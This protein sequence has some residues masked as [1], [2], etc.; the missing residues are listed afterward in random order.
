MR[1]RRAVSPNRAPALGKRV[2]LAVVAVALLFA[3]VAPPVGSA[4]AASGPVAGERPTLSVSVERDGSTVRYR[5]TVTAP[6]DADRVRLDGAFGVLTVANRSGF[7]AASGGYRLADGRKTA[8]L[9]VS[10]DLANHQ[11]TPLGR[12]GP[13]GPFQAGERWAFAPSPRFHV[14]WWTDG[15][16]E[17]ARLRGAQQGSGESAVTADQPVAVGERFVFVGP[18]RVAT[19]SVDGR[20]VRLILPD[21]ASFAV[22]AERAFALANRTAEAAGTTPPRPV[23]AFV[24]PQSVRAGG[25]ASGTDLWVRADASERTVA[26]EFAHAALGLRT[27]AET[28]WLSEA[29]AEYLAYRTT[30][31]GAVT[32]TLRRRVADPDAVL[33]DPGSWDDRAVAYRK[34]AALLALLDERVRAT[35]DGE[36]TLTAVLARLSETDRRIGPAELERVVTAVADERTATWLGEQANGTAPA[37]RP[38]TQA[39][40]AIPTDGAVGVPASPVDALGLVAALGALSVLVWVPLRLCYGLVVG[41]V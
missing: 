8:T 29:A 13:N 7:V 30:E 22:G 27:T 26:H 21:A 15:S 25:G 2:A 10:I 11:K 41:A 32:A 34:G 19:R 1:Q 38:A 14:R 20:S 9:T 4:G 36:H 23:T 3:A 35:T 6:E 5:A 17:H 18:H 16:V 24:L 37:V 28:R 33:A 31:E 40:L 12:V 39:G